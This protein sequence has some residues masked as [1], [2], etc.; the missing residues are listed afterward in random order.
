M[1]KINYMDP[2]ISSQ[3]SELHHKKSIAVREQE[4]IFKRE[5]LDLLIKAYED[6]RISCHEFTKS[7][8]E[9]GLV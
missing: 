9:N 6:E 3:I 2:I 5:V 8:E 7:L 1:G 4:E